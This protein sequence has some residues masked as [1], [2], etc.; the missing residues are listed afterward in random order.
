MAQLDIPDHKPVLI[1]T[2]YRTGS[3]ALC[4]TIA[5][6]LNRKNFDEAYHPT[7]FPER[8]REYMHYKKTNTD[9]VLKIMPDQITEANK[10]DIGT[11]FEQCYRIRLVRQDIVAQ[12][13][14][15]YV[16][17][18]TDFWHQTEHKQ[19]AVDTVPINEEFMLSCCHRI[20]WNN[21]Q[22]ASFPAE[23]FDANITYENIPGGIH[24]Q[25]RPRNRSNNYEEILQLVEQT[26]IDN[27]LA[28][29]KHAG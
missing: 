11:M 7:L 24:S 14:S 17:M 10:D 1:Y 27:E 23:A 9:F 15:W 12:I 13:A 19:M 16:S 6:Q 3:T 2:S 8:H 28:E 26:L 25:Y 20:L 18:V 22:V 29:K 21:D 4:D 5:S